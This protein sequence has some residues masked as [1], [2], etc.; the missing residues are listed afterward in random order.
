MGGT[1]SFL[2]TLSDLQYSEINLNSVLLSPSLI[3]AA[4]S[5]GFGI[6]WSEPPIT[7]QLCQMIPNFM[8]QV[9][10]RNTEKCFMEYLPVVPLPPGDNVCKWYLDLLVEMIDD[11]EAD[12]IFLHAELYTGPKGL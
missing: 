9:T 3:N 1:F 10:E 12:C 8:K 11:L 7:S 6:A 5:L 2:R 4:Q